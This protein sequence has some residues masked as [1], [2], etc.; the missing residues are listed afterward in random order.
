LGIFEVTFVGWSAPSDF[1]ADLDQ[2]MGVIGEPRLAAEAALI[3]CT[4]VSGCGGGPDADGAGLVMDP[5][6]GTTCGLIDPA[7]LSM[8]VMVSVPLGALRRIRASEM[9]MPN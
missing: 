3:A 7:G 5:A 2:R 8:L 9:L 6:E 4:I 1:D